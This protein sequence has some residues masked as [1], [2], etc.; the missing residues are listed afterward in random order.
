ML[1]VQFKE[2]IT[3]YRWDFLYVLHEAHHLPYYYESNFKSWN[4]NTQPADIVVLL[5]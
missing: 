5:K 3:I 1:Y 2:R 4:Q